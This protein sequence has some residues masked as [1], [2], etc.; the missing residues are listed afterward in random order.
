MQINFLYIKY[1]VNKMNRES[2]GHSAVCDSKESPKKRTLVKQIMI[3]P[4]SRGLPIKYLLTWKPIH[5]MLLLNT[6]L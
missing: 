4:Y 6:K 3:Y 2:L 1:S 5:N